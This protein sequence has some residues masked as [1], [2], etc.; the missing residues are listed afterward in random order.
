MTYPGNAPGGGYPGQGPQQ[1]PQGYPQAAPAGPK[2][3]LPQILHLAVAGLGLLNFFL[4]FA[5]VIDG[6]TANFFDVTSLIPGMFLIAGL[7]SAQVVLPVENK[8]PGIAPAAFALAAWLTILFNLF[9]G[10]AGVGVILL[11]I[12]GLIQ[13]AAAVG[14]FLFDN[15]IVKTPQPSAPQGHFGQPG[16]YN[17]PSAPFQQQGQPGQFGQPQQ[18]GQQGQQTTYVPPPQGQQ[19]T[20]APQQG[21]FGQQPPPGT[22]PG[23]YPQQQQG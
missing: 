21:Q 2:L 10:D 13:T 15:G 12:F 14:A 8:K 20:F 9:G 19:T 16:G 5:S 17:P 7:L 23:G 6:S 1:P 4:G 3:A 18:Q 22:P 11:V